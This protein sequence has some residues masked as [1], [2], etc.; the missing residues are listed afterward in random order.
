MA[1]SNPRQ[2]QECQICSSHNITA[3][4]KKHAPKKTRYNVKISTQRLCSD[5]HSL[6]LNILMPELR[7]LPDLS[8]SC[9]FSLMVIK[10]LK[11]TFIICKFPYCT[12][13]TRL[14][15]RHELFHYKPLAIFCTNSWNKRLAFS[16]QD[17]N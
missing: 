9:T 15:D 4:I 16:T 6:H 13:A 8:D 5:H 10:P 12:V 14:A 3:V 11:N 1:Q 2:C 7:Y 17:Q